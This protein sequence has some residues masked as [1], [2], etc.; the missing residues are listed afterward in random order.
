MSHALQAI[1]LA[2]GCSIA[3]PHPR[4]L[5]CAS[6]PQQFKLIPIT[7]E[8][9]DEVE[10]MYESGE[11]D[12]HAAFWRLS[13]SLRLFVL[14]LSRSGGV[15]YMET[16]YFGGSGEQAAAAWRFETLISPAIRS[17]KGPINVALK[18]IGAAVMDSRDEFEALALHEFCD[19]EAAV[20]ASARIGELEA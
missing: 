11:G 6:L 20:S 5:V 10:G 8:L 3:H 9:L 2:P 17:S 1:I 13:A 16:E 18:S 12:P 15:A 7:N 14:E 4:I 19:T